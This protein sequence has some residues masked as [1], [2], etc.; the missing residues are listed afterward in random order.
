MCQ[1]ELREQLQNSALYRPGQSKGSIPG[2]SSLSRILA[3]QEPDLSL[4]RST[5][6]VIAAG[7]GTTSMPM[8]ALI[9]LC[10][11]WHLLWSLLNCPAPLLPL[12]A[13]FLEGRI[14]GNGA[15]ISKRNLQKQT[16][17][18]TL[19]PRFRLAFTALVGIGAI[20]RNMSLAVSNS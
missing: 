11:N 5:M 13:C 3:S 4:D 1:A 12:L 15:R 18:L 17:E 14:A 16:Q 19:R 8:I 7:S 9:A 6:S 2:L 10:Q 20:L